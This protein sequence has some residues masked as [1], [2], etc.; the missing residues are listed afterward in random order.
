MKSN[1]G[2]GVCMT[3]P[4]FTRFKGFDARALQNVHGVKYAV[5]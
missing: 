2:F 5:V 1:G 3:R 4:T